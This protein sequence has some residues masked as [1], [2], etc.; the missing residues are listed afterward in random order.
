MNWQFTPLVVP[1]AGAALLSAGLAAYV[2][3]RR[4]ALEAKI[5]GILMIAV[6]EWSLC[7]ALELISATME[8]KVFWSKIQYV[9]IVAV[10]AAWLLF[11]LRYV[12]SDGWTYG[13][14]LGL[15]FVVPLLT[16][17]LV[18]TNEW[19]NWIWAEV[20]LMQLD[21]GT[22][23]WD[24]T[25]GW[26]FWAHTAY[27]YA[28]LLSA[29]VV[30]GRM[31]LDSSQLYRRQ[32]V[33]LIVGAAV[34]WL[35]NAITIW[36]LTPLPYDWTSVG[37]A[38]AGLLVTLAL[39]RFG[40]LGVSPIA[41]G[42]VVESMSDGVIVLD[43]ADR[44]IDLNASAQEIL[45]CHERE[46]IGGLLQDA[47]AP[48][49]DLAR[50]YREGAC[51]LTHAGGNQEWT[52]Q[53]PSGDIQQ[54]STDR[55]YEVRV[56]PLNIRGDL[57]GR[58]IVLRDVTERRRAEEA[59]RAQKQ[60]FEGLV[61]VAR[62]TSERPTLEAT[63]Q[64]ALTAATALTG[65]EYGT[66]LLLDEKGAVTHN[67][68]IRGQ[69]PRPHWRE[70]SDLVMV[71]GLAGW[72]TKHRQLVRISDTLQDDRWL[73]VPNSASDARSALAVPI[74]AGDIVLGVL[75]LTHSE[76]DHF[77]AEH[78]DLMASAGDLMMLSLRNA[79]IFD[80]QQR[81]AEHQSTLYH[82][83]RTVVGQFDPHS[84]VQFA[85]ESIAEFAGWPHVFVA[86][87][88][89]DQTE[90]EL[91]TFGMPLSLPAGERHPIDQGIVGRAIRTLRSQCVSDVNED[92]D[93][94][95]GHPDTKSKLVV[96]LRYGEKLFG[97]LDI[98]SDSVDAFDDRDVLLAES[99][100]D[101]MALAMEN[102][103]HYA[104]TRQQATDLSA[105]YTVTRMTSQSL[106]FDSVLSQALSSVLI[107]LEFEAGLIALTDPIDGRLYMAAEYGLPRHL[108]ERYKGNGMAGSL[109]E[110]VH[111]R[112]ESV[113]V[114]DARHEDAP[115][116]AGYAH[117][118]TRFG[119]RSY[120]G[121]PLLHR[122]T[123]FGAMSLFSHRKR[124]YPSDQMVLL[125]A[126]GRQVATA[127]TNARLF[128]ATVNE[129][130]RLTTLIESSRDGIILIDLDE[131][132]L[133]VNTMAI[134]FMRLPGDP[135]LWTERPV[136][137]ALNEL[138][139]Y[140][141]EM[142]AT[143][144]AEIERVRSGDAPPSE[145][146]VTIPPRTIHWLN[147]PVVTDAAPLGRL[148]VLRDVTEE[149][150][151][152]KMRDDL[153]HTMV[154]DLR[155]P[156]TGISTALKLLDT[157][158]SDV[159]SPA[160]HRLLEI[161][162]SSAER[163]VDLVS[164]ILDVSR[165]ESGRMPINPVSVPLR[166]LVAEALELQ[167]PLAVTNDLELVDD[168]PLDLPPAWADRELIGRVLQNLVGNA[169][170]FTPAKGQITITAGQCE[171]ISQ[172]IPFTFLCISV[173][174]T[175]PGVPVDLRDNLFQK[176]VVGEQQEHG[177]GLGLAFC[178]LAVEAHGGQIW[179]ES[180]PGQGATFTFSLPIAS[181]TPA[182]REDAA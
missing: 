130:Q 28:V 134:E 102:A 25:Y 8:G 31:L 124:R 151:L 41:R 82:V 162:D 11:T 137:D 53:T 158:L 155:N 114:R 1:L 146:E 109:S 6:A 103:S 57:A 170:K 77:T 112:R 88:D 18:W 111:E 23:L 46:V 17:A 75:T 69:D 7:A 47:V 133:V 15:L 117:D 4:R 30:L 168:V 106:S 142:A 62:A 27:S 110:L 99:L 113:I 58:L 43:C 10:P 89:E 107:S 144:L 153:T 118:M 161:A 39:Y 13:W 72:A 38:V 32:V 131:Q 49:S 177:S 178:K 45:G 44:I 5:L 81:M 73:S 182:A 85:A 127:V 143:T 141:P 21:S 26:A 42:L 104:E 67:L 34:S 12:G 173:A 154:H 128:Q 90:W 166:T 129:R 138:R 123:S 145:W 20:T 163:M 132:I 86:L 122:D 60:L 101:T 157:K 22:V 160:Q 164:A 95:V 68:M 66:L 97:A 55:L 40:F 3:T 96:P 71:S 167:S 63:L 54:P 56:S 147:L 139:E 59:T 33:I 136:E 179:V 84:V 78:A 79:Q 120:A 171:Q 125:E 98:E 105:L 149:R 19:H 24:A 74:V 181:E 64:N 80:A 52:E 48:D 174:D 150:M 135:S 9:G 16:V 36:G 37:F 180:D 126:I 50:L 115:S 93:H 175:G 119:L 172:D 121:I 35:G 176:F 76:A 140:A 94:I 65:A 70:I 148:L 87:I 156:L 83:L 152:A 169:I 116:L 2:W 92:A 108:S 51:D 91:H 14:R 61:E 165:L 29:T 100:A 159:M